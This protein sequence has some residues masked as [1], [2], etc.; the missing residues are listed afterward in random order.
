MEYHHWLPGKRDDQ[1]HMAKTWGTILTVKGQS[2]NVPPGDITELANLI[3]GADTALALAKSSER[4]QVITAQCRGA[5]DALLAKMRYIKKRS[6]LQPPL[7]DGDIISLLLSL[8]DDTRTEVPVPRLE[9]EGDI[10]FPD[11]GIIEVTNIRPR[12]DMNAEDRRAYKGV[13]I[14]YGLTGNPTAADLFRL[15]EAPAAGY[16]LPHSTWTA[17]KSHRFQFPGESGN[18]IYLCLRYENG[19]GGSGPWGPILTAIIP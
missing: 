7:T 18:R 13:R 12:G 19:K 15:T 10:H 14:Y 9:A 2:W 5:F 3:A 17:R 8:H 1:I 6:F 4:T 16:Q 11:Y